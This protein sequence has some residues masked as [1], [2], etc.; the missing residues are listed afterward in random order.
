MGARTGGETVT[1]DEILK[2]MEEI[3]V[4]FA[5]TSKLQQRTGLSDQRVRERVQRLAEAGRI[6]REKVGRHWVYWLPKYTY[7]DSK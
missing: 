6:K 4:P 7:S 5:T 3:S 2:A 1:D